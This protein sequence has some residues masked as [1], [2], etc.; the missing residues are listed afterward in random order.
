[1]Q[2][3]IADR[4]TEKGTW[5]SGHS[6]DALMQAARREAYADLWFTMAPKTINKREGES[7][8]AFE[9]RHARF[10]AQLRQDADDAAKAKYP[11]VDI[12]R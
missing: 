10:I 7:R 1:M 6:L 8:Q 3:A 2:G 4:M 5:I 12:A 9:A 11:I